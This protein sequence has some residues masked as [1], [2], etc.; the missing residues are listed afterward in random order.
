MTETFAV[1]F[2]HICTMFFFI[3]T[4]FCILKNTTK[5]LKMVNCNHYPP[6]YTIIQLKWSHLVGGFSMTISD[7]ESKITIQNDTNMPKTN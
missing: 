3:N 2:I 6:K 5:P 1:Y 4:Y 7:R